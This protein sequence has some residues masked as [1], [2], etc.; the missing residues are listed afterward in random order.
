MIATDITQIDNMAAQMSGHPSNFIAIDMNDYN[1]VKSGSSYLIAT[2]VEM[3]RMIANGMEHFKQ[4]I[5][6]FRAE[7]VNQILLQVCGVS[8]TLEVQPISFREMCMILNAVEE[9]F[10][11]RDDVEPQTPHTTSFADKSIS[12]KVNI[13]WGVSDRTSDQTNGYEVYIIAGYN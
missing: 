5:K 12:Q 1:R 13:V 4:A 8:S 11:Q 3:P 6:E 10:E 2:R 7:G 9:H